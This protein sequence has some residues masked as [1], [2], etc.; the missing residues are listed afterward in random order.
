MQRWRLML[1]KYRENRMAAVR[2]YVASHYSDDGSRE[3]V[4]VNL[5]AMYV[6]TMTRNLVAK[7]PRVMLST[8]QREHKPVVHALQAWGNKEIEQMHFAETMKRIVIDALFWMGIGKVALATPANAATKA[9]SLEA[10]KPF[11]ERVDPDD[12]VCDMSV[13]DFQDCGIIGHRYRVPLEVIRDSPLYSKARK[14]LVPAVGQ[15]FNVEGDERIGSVG[16]GNL[17]F[18][19]EE[20][21]DFVDL[22]EVY[23]T[24]RR[25]VYTFADN[26]F[27]GP[28]TGANAEFDEPLRVQ[29]WV[30]PDNGPYYLLGL[31]TV[32]GNLMPL[33][34]IN[35][36]IDLHDDANGSYRKLERTMQR[37]KENTLVQGSESEDGERLRNA[38]DGEMVPINNPERI[39]QVVSSGQHIQPLMLGAGMF[40][41]LF[42]KMAGG[43]ELQAGVAPQAKTLG[44]DKMLQENSNHTVSDMQ[45]QT[46]AYSEKVLRGLFWYWWK[47]PFAVQTSTHSLPGMPEISVQRAITPAMRA[48]GKFEDA[49]LRIHPYSMQ[50]KAPKEQLAEIDAMVTNLVVPM[51]PQMQGQGIY[52]D[53]NAYL[54]IR[55]QLSDMPQMSEL[56]TI[57]DPPQDT[58]SAGETAAQQGKETT[59]NRVSMPGRTQKGND[60][61][62]RSALMGVDPGGASQNGQMGVGA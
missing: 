52:F 26:D 47:D 62:I 3:K 16:R 24:R 55:A 60:E 12:F 15:Q 42:D 37:M 50:Y 38:Q 41:D 45:D 10:G 31:G 36:L 23:D 30:G 43:I 22:W 33:G 4:P 19:V 25:L 46:T 14:E 51:Q 57:A 39:K 44:Q 35:N 34:P 11:F 28:T 54:R 18:N 20:Y 56:L 8:F 48:R 1:R 27:A 21:E 6:Q 49:E 32:P 53:W 7:N 40:K 61:N 2:K 5:L 13:N 9:W 17:G 29:S 59:H 58:G